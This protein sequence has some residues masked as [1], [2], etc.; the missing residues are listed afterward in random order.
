MRKLKLLWIALVFL[1]G[2]QADRASKRWAEAHLQGA[3]LNVVDKVL[4]FRYAENRAIAF[5]MLARLPDAVRRPLVLALS[6]AAL[7]AL[8]VFAW[9]SRNLGLARLAPLALIFAGALGNLH[10]RVAKGYVVDFV[11][12]H[13][14]AS[15]SFAIFNVADSL[16]CVGAALLIV[17]WY[18]SRPARPSP[19][20]S[21]PSP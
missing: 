5:S 2:C 20:P 8:L 4:E 13:W 11:R 6:G 19:A 10:D 9:R 17:S 12:V 7:T 21:L 3:P 1:T 15:W 18:T 14:G 16:I